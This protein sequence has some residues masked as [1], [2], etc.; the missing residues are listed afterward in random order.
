MNS[1]FR[2]Q[3]E[4]KF[5]KN[6][7]FPK[8]Y[9]LTLVLPLLRPLILIPEDCQ[10]PR[11]IVI[12]INVKGLA[13]IGTGLQGNSDTSGADGRDPISACQLMRIGL[14]VI[15]IYISSTSPAYADA[16]TDTSIYGGTKR[17]RVP[18]DGGGSGRNRDDLIRTVDGDVTI[19]RTGNTLT[20]EGTTRRRIFAK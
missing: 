5:G 9:K 12:I 15:K 6:K 1:F 17:G 20:S 8:R 13:V 10:G 19:A 11:D 3:D 2:Q 18:S 16:I 4:R 7:N 14:I